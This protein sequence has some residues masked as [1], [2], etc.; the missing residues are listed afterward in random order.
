MVI[1]HFGGGVGHLGDH[2]DGIYAHDNLESNQPATPESSDDETMDLQVNSESVQDHALHDAG[3]PG[4][5]DED[6]GEGDD[7]LDPAMSESDSDDNQSIDSQDSDES[8]LD[9]DDDGYASF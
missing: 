8:N 2:G 5:D 3:E 9:D 1:R 4:E 6:D 7:D